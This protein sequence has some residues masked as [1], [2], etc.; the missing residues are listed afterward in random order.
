LEIFWGED[1]RCLEGM[2]CCGGRRR[3]S[4]T[5]TIWDASIAKGLGCKMGVRV[6]LHGELAVKSEPVREL[7]VREIAGAG[8]YTACPGAAG[9][10]AAEA[11]VAAEAFE[12]PREAGDRDRFGEAGERSLWVSRL[13]REI[14]TLETTGRPSGSCVSSGS[15]AMDR[16]LPS[17]GIVCGSMLELVHGIPRVGRSATGMPHREPPVRGLGAM[18]I[19]MRLVR[20]WIADGKYAV[21]IDRALQLYAPGLAAL[22]IPVERLIVLR[23]QTEADAIWGMDQALRS[24]AVGGV[25][26]NVRHLDDRAARRLQ[27]AAERGGGVGILLRDAVSARLHP[28]W[29]EVQW[30]VRGAECRAGWETRWFDLELTRAQG[31]KPGARVR[32]GLNASGEWVDGSKDSGVQHEQTAAKHLAAQ[33]AQPARR[34]REVAG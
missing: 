25:V 1:H 11:T 3:I 17:G 15:L 20:E 23:P 6:G 14:R 29:A 4:W 33:L 16:S 28:S 26:A 34:R 31:G 8:G 18:A 9:P 7:A 2:V 12:P 24:G 10:V 30:R 21:V 19:A 5:A 27:L 13:S 22:G 32:I